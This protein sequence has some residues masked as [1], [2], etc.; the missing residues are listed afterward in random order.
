MPKTDVAVAWIEIYGFIAS[1]IFIVEGTVK[2]ERSYNAELLC[3]EAEENDSC[4]NILIHPLSYATL[5]S[6]L[7]KTKLIP[8]IYHKNCIR[9]SNFK[10]SD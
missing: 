4:L 9:Y 3:E 10:Q 2:Q 8:F 5:Y 6:F 1:T 7:I